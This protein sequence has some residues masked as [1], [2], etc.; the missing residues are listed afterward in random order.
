MTRTLLQAALDYTQQGLHVIPLKPRSKIPAYESGPGHSTLQSKDEEQIRDWWATNPEFNIG[1]PC[2]EPNRLAV[3]DIDGPTGENSWLETFNEAGRPDMNETLHVCSGRANGGRHIY[4][5]WPPGQTITSTTIRP[6]ID[7]IA[8]GK[9]IV[10]PPSIHPDTGQPYSVTRSHHIAV[11]PA[12][13][14]AVRPTR[15][16]PNEDPPPPMPAPERNE[17]A[18]RRLHGLCREVAAAPEGERNNRL[19]HAA[20]ISGRLVASGHLDHVH[21]TTLLLTAAADAGLTNAKEINATLKSGIDAGIADGPDPNHTETSGTLQ[22]TPGVRVATGTEATIA[23]DA[24]EPFTDHPTP[25]TQILAGTWNPPT[26]TILERT[27]HNHLIYPGQTH[28]IYGEPE[29]GKTWIAIH[30]TAQTLTNGGTV[31][32]I[33]YE[34]AA[35]VVVGRLRQ[36]LRHTNFG[37]NFHHWMPQHPYNQQHQQ[38]WH[39]HA[40]NYELVIL[41]GLAIA[42]AM[43]GYDENSNKD[44]A[45]FYGTITNPIAHQGPAVIIID[46]TTKQ[47]SGRWARGAGHK[48]AGLNGATYK[49]K[50]TDQPLILIGQGRIR[51]ELSKDRHGA[52]TLLAD[53]TK[54][55]HVADFYLE[56]HTDGTATARLEPPP[57]PAKII[58]AQVL[59]Y[60]EDEGP[61]SKTTIEKNVRGKAALIRTVVVEMDREGYIEQTAGPRGGFTYYGF[62][63]RVHPNTRLTLSHE[64][65]DSENVGQGTGKRPINPVPD[66]PYR[67]TGQVKTDP[68]PT[69]PKNNPSKEP[70]DRVPP[71]F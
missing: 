55:R 57:D 34:N 24:G 62:V 22:V 4:Y 8:D 63:T 23:T 42:L 38:W 2:G 56:G 70:R 5:H 1:I 39:E 26:P 71:P 49:A 54:D 44:I 12:W 16:A 41:D 47:D 69:T 51:L 27:D 53:Q 46:H 67:G 48:L 15:I 43:N 52:I 35:T 6:G 20:Y 36:L 30:A 13:L 10:A 25:T 40:A 32:Y 65:N 14:T 33:D 61:A 9:Q 21:A 31:A 68:V 18:K 28:A 37:P 19:N 60:L 7:L 3:V 11:M 66:P 64:K 29:T 59:N 45:T 17:F 58:R 50:S